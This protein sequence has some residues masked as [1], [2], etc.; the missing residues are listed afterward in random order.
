MQAAE[1]ER[2]AGQAALAIVVAGDEDIGA[3]AVAGAGWEAEGR[4]S[5][6]VE[7]RALQWHGWAKAAAGLD[8]QW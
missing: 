6:A 7:S 3:A 2:G 4:A 5:T 8:P 1:E